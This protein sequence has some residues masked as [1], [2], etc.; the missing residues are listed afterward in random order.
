MYGELKS[1]KEKLFQV[2]KERT[3]QKIH[4]SDRR[5]IRGLKVNNQALLND[6]RIACEL[7]RELLYVD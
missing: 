6:L 2:E 3:Y 5:E 1:T 4:E 7:I